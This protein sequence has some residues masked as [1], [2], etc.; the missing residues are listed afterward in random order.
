MYCGC[1]HFRVNAAFS[2][3]PK[4]R[5]NTFDVF[6]HSASVVTVC[7]KDTFH[8]SPCLQ[9]PDFSYI[10]LLRSSLQSACVV[11]GK[12]MFSVVSCLSFWSRRGGH[13]TTTHDAIAKSQVIW[14]TPNLFEFVHLEIPSPTGLVQTCSLG[15]PP[16]LPL[17]TSIGKR[18]VDLRLK[19]LLENIMA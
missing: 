4:K 7:S 19:G 9:L 12:L 16:P 13:V 3:N 14:G 10:A 18:V 8:K 5:Q 15:D 17:Q 11:C 1:R 2:W 6:C